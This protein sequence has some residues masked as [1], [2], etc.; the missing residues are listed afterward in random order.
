MLS[1]SAVREVS[2][3]WIHLQPPR[4]PRAA[5]VLFA[6]GPFAVRSA[7]PNTCVYPLLP[8]LSRRGPAAKIVWVILELESTIRGPSSF[9]RPCTVERHST[10][11][12]TYN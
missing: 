10:G 6:L 8:R 11:T 2:A 9:T 4:E 3:S 1:R 7:D 12:E 5:A